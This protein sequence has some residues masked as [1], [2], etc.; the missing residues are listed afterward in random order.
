MLQTK[1]RIRKLQLYS[2]FAAYNTHVSKVCSC[3][4]IYNH[5][6]FCCPSILKHSQVHVQQSMHTLG[7]LHGW[8]E[9]EATAY[10]A[11]D[12]SASAGVASLTLP[13]LFTTWRRRKKR[14]KEERRK[15][16][17]RGR[18]RRGGGGR[19]AQA[20]WNQTK[21]IKPPTTVEP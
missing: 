20:A 6:Q 10:L 14:R 17:R 12:A 16:R 3:Y 1:G 21:A 8:V 18:R 4:K 15:K 9:G 11:I 5:E 7:C 19:R 13:P 2:S